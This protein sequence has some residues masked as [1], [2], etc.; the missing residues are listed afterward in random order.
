MQDFV[1][2]LAGTLPEAAPQEPKPPRFRTL[3]VVSALVLRETG[4]SDTRSSLG[5]LWNLIDPVISVIMLSIVFSVITRTPRMGTNFPLYYITGVVPFHIYTA[6]NGRVSTS[7]RY[8]RSLLQ[9]P[10]VTVIDVIL[11]RLILNAVTNIC[12]FIILLFLVNWYY[13]LQLQPDMGPLLMALAMS[14]TLGLGVGVLNAILFLASPTYESIWSILNRP[15]LILSG[16]MFRIE[17]LPAQ[18]FNVLKWNPQAQMI[19]E[20]RKAFYPTYDI[21]W[22][23]PSYVFLIAGVTLALGLVG[24]HR[25]VLDAL[26]T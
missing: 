26:D 6:I 10:S 20:M 13:D 5:F 17:D 9:F 19:A 16:V 8:S 7:M 3:R 21:P 12:V 25:W 24:L 11:A 15:M 23:Y 22:V 1:A 14:I 2:D 18:L 4:S